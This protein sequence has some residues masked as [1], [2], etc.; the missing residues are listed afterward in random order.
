MC[1]GITLP[2]EILLLKNCRI[3]ALGKTSIVTQSLKRQLPKKYCSV[4]TSAK[5]VMFLSLFVCLSLCLL[6]TLRKNSRTDLH[7]IF[8]EVWQWANEQTIKFWW[9]SRPPSGYGDCF[10]DSSLSWE[11]RKVV[12][13][14]CAAR[15][16]SAGQACIAIAI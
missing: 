12:S 11:I 4:I 15:R 2:G 6:A 7:E 5:E 9:K 8:R 13:T 1:C 10:S 3:L 14:D 16:C